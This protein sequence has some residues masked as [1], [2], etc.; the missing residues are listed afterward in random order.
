M[1]LSLEEV[2]DDL[3][4]VDSLQDCL[5]TSGLDAATMQAAMAYKLDEAPEWVQRAEEVDL[6]SSAL[7]GPA[8]PHYFRTCH[9]RHLGTMSA[10]GDA[11]AEGGAS[12]RADH[13]GYPP[14]GDYVVLVVND[15]MASTE[16]SHIILMLCV[17]DLGR[18]HGLP[19]QL[20]GTH[21]RR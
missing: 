7:T 16:V 9:R 11:A 15:S 8:A 17:A 6:S 19:R 5:T 21:Q 4:A 3:E 10:H 2:Q 13:R 18:M 1:K 20:H 14:S 12:H